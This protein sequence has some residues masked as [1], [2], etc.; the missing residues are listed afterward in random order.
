MVF[1]LSHWIACFWFFTTT[2]IEANVKKTW[3]IDNSIA[4]KNMGE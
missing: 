1:L 4:S 3:A 2:V